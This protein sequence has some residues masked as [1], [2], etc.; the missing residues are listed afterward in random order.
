MLKRINERTSF[1]NVA[2]WERDYE[3]SQYYKRNHCAYPSIDFYKTQKTF[4]KYKNESKSMPKSNFPMR[5]TKYKFFEDYDANDFEGVKNIQ[6]EKKRK[7]EEEKKRIK[8]EEENNKPKILYKT[9]S[10]FSELGNC[11]VEFSVQTQKFNVKIESNDHP[12]KAYACIFDNRESIENIQKYY[13]KYDEIISDLNYNEEYDL[14]KFFNED[15]PGLECVRFLNLFY[16]FFRNV[17]KFLE[18]KLVML[19]EKINLLKIKRKIKR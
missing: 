15:K 6:S 14:I 3:K 4:Y 2:K 5:S 7:E 11:N 16:F 12:E 10:V 17:L 13:K 1:Y 8:K 18:E 9:Q 19:K